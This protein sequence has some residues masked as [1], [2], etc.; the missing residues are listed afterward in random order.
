MASRAEK[1]I[2]KYVAAVQPHIDEPVRS[3][4]VA[5][6]E[7]GMFKVDWAGLRD[8]L[9]ASAGGTPW[10]VY[11]AVTGGLSVDE[12]P[13]PPEELMLVVTDHDLRVIEATPWFVKWHIKDEFGRWSRDTVQVSTD[14]KK[15][16]YVLTVAGPDGERVE[17]AIARN[18][19]SAVQLFLE[20][21]GTSP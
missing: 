9:V 10:F 8:G 17:F 11:K 12:V 20:A 2:A 5:E 14:K 6:P 7:E 18:L 1:W 4:I 15:T 19:G 16:R 21:L 3:A 13:K